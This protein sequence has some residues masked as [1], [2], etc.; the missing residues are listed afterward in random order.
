M[1]FEFILDGYII[2]LT[3]VKTSNLTYFLVGCSRP[4]WLDR[5]FLEDFYLLGC[6]AV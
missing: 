3:A 1:V 2:I 4:Y 6:S 5:Y